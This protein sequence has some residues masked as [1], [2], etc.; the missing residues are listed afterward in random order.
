M[1]LKEE[2]RAVVKADGC[3]PSQQPLFDCSEQKILLKKVIAESNQDRNSCRAYDTI[4]NRNDHRF[5]VGI[6]DHHGKSGIFTGGTC[7]SN[8]AVKIQ[9]SGNPGNREERK[10]FPHQVT[11]ES[12]TA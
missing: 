3:L 8:T 12:D 10:N 1:E 11:E 5:F 9:V 7:R 6:A 2:N 4:E